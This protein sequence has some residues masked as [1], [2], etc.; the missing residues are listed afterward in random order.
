MLVVLKHCHGGTR[1]AA[2]T[3][4]VFVV[5]K[6]DNDV[7]VVPIPASETETEHQRIRKSNDHDQKME[8]EGRVSR[9]NRGDRSKKTKTVEPVSLIKVW[10]H[11][12]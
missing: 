2:H 4:E 8:R 7:T 5:D 3:A 11:V 1:I 12:E 9:H 6:N 10:P